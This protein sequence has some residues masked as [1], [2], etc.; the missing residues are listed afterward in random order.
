MKNTHPLRLLLIG[1]TLVSAAASVALLIEKCRIEKSASALPARRATLESRFHQKHLPPSSSSSRTPQNHPHAPTPSAPAPATTPA[2]HDPLPEELA[3]QTLQLIAKRAAFPTRYAPF[4]RSQP[5]SAPQ[6]TALEDL[7]SRREE[8]RLDLAAVTRSH[9]LPA[10]DPAIARLRAQADRE[11]RQALSQLIGAQPAE[12]LVEFERKLPAWE[13][14]GNFAGTAALEG[15]PITPDQAVELAEVI[16]S[17]SPSYQ[18]GN[19][20]SPADVNW[21]S[22]LTQTVAVLTPPQAVSFRNMA[23]RYPIENPAAPAGR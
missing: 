22:V 5:L 19:D 1:L 20:V 8:Q 2:T 14:V 23:P 11:F 10:S 13:L 18:A 6:L 15:Q 4:L 12:T 17:A 7:L 9:Q 3:L 16:A 21:P